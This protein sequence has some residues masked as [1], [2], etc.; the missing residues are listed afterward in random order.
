MICGWVN[1]QSLEST[2][3]DN[4]TVNAT[5]DYK[6]IKAGINYRVDEA[7]SIFSLFNITKNIRFGAAYD[8]TTS[9]I[10]EINNNGSIEM[11]IRYQF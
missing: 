9:D 5:V 1:K 7:Y 11:L 8:F 4:N 2:C 6:N 3:A 10:S